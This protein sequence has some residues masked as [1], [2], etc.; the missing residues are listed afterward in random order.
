MKQGTSHKLLKITA[1]PVVRHLGAVAAWGV[2]AIVI[3]LLQ[4]TVNVN[5]LL[6]ARSGR[7]SWAESV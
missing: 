6:A 3:F 4:T 5:M 1:H 2:L 7:F